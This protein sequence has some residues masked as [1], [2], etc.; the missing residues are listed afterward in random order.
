MTKD[1]LI[2]V[3]GLHFSSEE[4]PGKVEVINAGNYYKED[5][6][7]C[8]MYEE[9]MEGFDQV[10]ENLIRFKDGAAYLQKKGI[11]NVDMQFEENRKNTSCYTTP[12]GDVM[13]GITTTSVSISEQEDQIVL[14]V[15][16]ELDANY[17]RLADCKIR[18][19]VCPKESGTIAF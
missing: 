13:L 9:A 11:I 19:R 16:Y 10:T 3:E 8:V 4:V 18:I 17:E 5:D 6:Y 2:S 7:H 15:D 1:V 12:F 14:D